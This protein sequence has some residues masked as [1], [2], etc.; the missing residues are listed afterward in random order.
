MKK[1]FEKNLVYTFAAGLLFFAALYTIHDMQQ[2]E[3]VGYYFALLFG[4]SRLFFDLCVDA[5]AGLG[6]LVL[7]VLGCLYVKKFLA[8]MP[9]ADASL[10][11][12]SKPS[13]AGLFFRA[14]ILLLSFLPSLS[15]AYLLHPA[16]SGTFYETPLLLCKLIGPF[17]LL[18][19]AAESCRKEGAD[20][21]FPPLLHTLQGKVLLLFAL[22]CLLCGMCLPVWAQLL[23][24][25]GTYCLLL[26]CLS[27]LESLLWRYPA[28]AKWQVILEAGLFLRGLY[29]LLSVTA[30]Y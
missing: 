5:A 22:G 23:F 14:E 19:L 25:F 1:T 11:K 3:G 12:G 6:L 15:L 8:K 10:A 7:I 24:F 18:L 27:L 29:V 28:F 4:K 20:S 16:K 17:F 26:L 21:A 9:F 30:A 2:A 13:C